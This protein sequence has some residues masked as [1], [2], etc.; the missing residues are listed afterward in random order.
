METKHPNHH[1]QNVV[2]RLEEAQAIV[3]VCRQNPIMAEDLMVKRLAS[4]RRRVWN[5]A[6][7]LLQHYVG[8]RPSYPVRGQMEYHEDYQSRVHNYERMLDHYLSAVAYVDILKDRKVF[9]EPAEEIA[10]S[11]V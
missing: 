7:Q 1:S 6:I 2:R 10:V 8:E 11:H 5:R 4:E 9:E 3:L